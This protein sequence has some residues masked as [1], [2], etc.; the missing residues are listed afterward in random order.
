M[1][2]RGEKQSILKYALIASGNRSL[3]HLFRKIGILELVFIHR[4]CLTEKKF[5]TKDRL[6]LK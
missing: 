3:V 1:C 6:F 4:N 2:I 5:F